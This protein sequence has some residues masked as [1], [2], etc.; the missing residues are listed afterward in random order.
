[1]SNR[2]DFEQQI[3]QCWGVVEDIDTLYETMMEQDVP[4]EHIINALL[5]M[6]HLYNMK[7]DRMFQTF[8]ILISEKKL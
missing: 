3:M 6:K 5:G 2:F 8:E 7:F 4:K 1:M